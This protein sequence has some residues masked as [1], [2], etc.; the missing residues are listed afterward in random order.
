MII[1][2]PTEIA[3]PAPNDISE[4]LKQRTAA[5]KQLYSCPNDFAAHREL[6]EA[7][8]KVRSGKLGQIRIILFRLN[9]GLL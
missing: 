2:E 8:E 6:R 4:T 7:N 3:I 1:R 5:Q 9:C